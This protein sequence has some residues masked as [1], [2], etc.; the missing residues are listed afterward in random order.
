MKRFYKPETRDWMLVNRLIHR[1][2]QR[3]YDVFSASVLTPL[4]II[5]WDRWPPDVVW[6]QK[7]ANF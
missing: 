3:G 1:L 2:V 6:K 7:D 5:A 4:N